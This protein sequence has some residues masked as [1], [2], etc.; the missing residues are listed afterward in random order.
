MKKKKQ[1]ARRFIQTDYDNGYDA[2]KR[3]E[4]KEN[5]PYNIKANSFAWYSW[6]CGW[7]A[8]NEVYGD[9]KIH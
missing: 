9:I 2:R 6:D 3:G 4:K 8:A 7:R 5:N 1:F